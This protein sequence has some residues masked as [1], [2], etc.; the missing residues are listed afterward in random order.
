MASPTDY[1]LPKFEN[2]QGLT[3]GTVATIITT[4]FSV[5]NYIAQTQS[6]GYQ[7]SNLFKVFF[8]PPPV[9][10]RIAGV[11]LNNNPNELT[12][13]CESTS[14]P[15]LSLATTEVRRYG[16]G[17][18]ERKP[19]TPIFNDIQLSF[20]ADGKGEVQRFFTTWMHNIVN[21]TGAGRGPAGVRNSGEQPPYIANYKFDY[22]CQMLI[23]VYNNKGEA[24]YEYTLNQAY[25]TL[26]GEIGL[27]W[28]DTDQ[29]VRLPITFTFL[30]W[31]STLITG[32]TTGTS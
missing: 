27:N 5:A 26:M 12:L 18:V 21:F 3:T 10:R 29:L 23:R 25:P 14:L 8:F 19:Y 4:G 7:K 11:A 31:N 22:C 1:R 24:V 13:Y 32:Q 20:I 15:G 30:D 28:A 16:Y 6:R 9:M 2:T 17:P